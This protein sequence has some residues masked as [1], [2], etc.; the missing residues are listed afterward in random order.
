MKS[1]RIG[2]FSAWILLFILAGTAGSGDKSGEKFRADLTGDAEVPVP[3]A[4][5][6]SG[7]F[8]MA[9]DSFDYTATYRIRL[10]D[11][12]RVF[13]AHIHCGPPG[14]NGPIVVWLAGNPGGELAWDV[15]G[16]WI[17]NAIF[18]DA[19]VIPGSGCGDTLADLIETLRNGGAY[20]NAHTR[21]NPGG[22]VRGQIRL[23]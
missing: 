13:M 7:D 14:Q 4:T 17:D 8:R 2:A 3:I 21:A 12:A 18:T 20:V 9:Y 11:G 16:K 22:E 19:D 5:D 23:Q 15:D 10:N 1:P 6:T